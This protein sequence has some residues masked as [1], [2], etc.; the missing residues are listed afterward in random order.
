[1]RSGSLLGVALFAFATARARAQSPA[2]PAPPA[3]TAAG[4][5]RPTLYYIPHTHWEGAVFFTREEYLEAG[6][7]HVLTAVQMLERHADW[8]FTLDQVAYIKPFLE[9]YPE[10][11][12]AFRRFVAEGRLAIVGGMDVMP[13]DVKPGGELFV[14]QVQYGKGWCRDELGVDVTVAWMLDTFGH[15]PQMPQ[16]LR[17]AGFRSFWFCRGVPNDRLPSEFHW[18]G[19]DGTTIPAFWLP[20]FYGLFYGPPRD[21]EGFARFFEE[22]FHSL[23]AHARGAERVGLAGVDVC[24]PEQDVPPL[25]RAFDARP[26]APFTIRCSVPEEFA[27]VVARRT[28]LPTLDGDFNPI[29]QGTYSSRIELHQERRALEQLLLSAENLCAVARWLDLAPDEEGLAKAWEPLLFATTHDLASGVMTDPVYEDVVQSLAYSRRLGEGVLDDAWN[30]LGDRI[31]ARGEGLPVV[32]FNGLAWPRSDLVEVDVGNVDPAVRDYEV[33]GPAGETVP[34][35]IGVRERHLDGS[36]RRTTVSFVATVPSLGYAVH[37]VVPRAAVATAV[38]PS[39]SDRAAGADTLENE[40]FTVRIEPATGAVTSLVDRATGEEL[41]S[42]P[43]NVVERTVDPGDLWEIGRPLD[44]GMYLAVSTP[45]PAPDPKTTLLSTATPGEP[46]RFQRGPVVSTFRSARD[47]GGGRITTEV[48]LVRGVRRVEFETELVNREKHVRYQVAFPTAI[49]AG[50]GTRLTQEIPFG[51][52]VRPLGVEYPAQNWSDLADSKRGVALLNAG[53]PGNL[54]TGATL[55]LS[56]L[57]SEDLISYNEGRPSTTGFELDVP[58][59]LRYAVT[60]HSGAWQ[61]STIVRQGFELVR[62]LLVRKLAVP[63]KDAPASSTALLP[64]RASLVDLSDPHVVVTAFKPGPDD[65]TILRLYDSSGRGATDVKVA[66]LAT[67]RSAAECD[68]LE[69][70]LHPLSTDGHSVTVDLHPFQIL[71]LRLD[72]APFGR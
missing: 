62:P 48:R 43:G 66:L 65:S 28:D 68:L 47:F 7:S 35:Q 39:A 18:R 60:S 57:R 31:D 2:P 13:D 58:R 24:E 41:L 9:R 56:L 44:G 22:R 69:R 40:F 1:M 59:R 14:R 6:L 38:V 21:A 55:R 20:G 36:L 23:D 64:P 37:H 70:S 3:A 63:S 53:L 45:Q 16:L 67:I 27:E 25:I 19:I 11:A 61:D 12:P 33:R 5:G 50:E 8:R 30:S 17:L 51:A 26:D 10:A 4:A 42:A 71:T 52:A 46:G 49:E 34:C 32:V 15:H 54:A 72:L 29:F